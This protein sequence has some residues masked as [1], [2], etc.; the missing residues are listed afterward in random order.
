[1]SVDPVRWLNAGGPLAGVV[2]AFF[3]GLA[4]A[5]PWESATVALLSVLVFGPAYLIQNTVHGR[6]GTIPPPTPKTPAEAARSDARVLRAGAVGDFAIAVAAVVLAAV[7]GVWFQGSGWTAVL[8]IT[9]ALGLSR[10]PHLWALAE[11]RENQR[12]VPLGM[13]AGWRV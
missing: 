13:V 8:L 4:V 12:T 9:A 3:G 2:V 1:M 11:L 6:R 7:G 5:G 10:A